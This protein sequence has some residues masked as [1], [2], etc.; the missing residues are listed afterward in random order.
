[1]LCLAACGGGGSGTISGK[2]T[3]ADGSDA[4][5]LAVTLLGPVGKRVDTISGGAYSFDKL[6]KGVYQVSVEGGDTRERRLSFGTESD[7]STAIMAPDL[8]F[9]ALATVTG[10]VMTGLGPAEGAT[11]YLSG[12]DRVAL[13]DAAGSY[14]FFEVPVG[15]YS[16]VA[17]A[18]GQVPQQASA[19]LKLKRGKNEA[20]LLTLGND[21]TVTGKLEGTL[22]LFNGFSPKD[23]RVSVAD[24]STMTSESGGFSL[25]LP[26]GEYEAIAGLAGY[27]KQSLGFATVRPG[28]TTTLPVK[29]LSV[30]KAFPWPSRISGLSWTAASESDVA[31]LQVNVD[32]DYSTEY[33]FLDTK[34]FARRLFAIGFI[35]QLHLSK[36][37]KWA[38][39]VPTSGKGVVAINSAT[40]QS[41]SLG[42]TA[43]SSGPFISNDETTMMFF[44][45][46]LLV[47]FDLNTGASNTF[48]ANAGSVFQSNERFLA[49]NT[50]PGPFDVQLITPSSA[51]TVFNSVQ[52]VGLSPA[53]FVP[54][55]QLAT[56]S[57]WAY[58]CPIGNCTVSVLGPTAASAT[59]VTAVIPS[60]PTAI[61]GSVADWI[62]LQAGVARTLIKVA[63]GTG[64]PLPAGASQLTFSETQA[65]V[66][67]HSFN[68]TL[69]TYELRED[70]VPPNAASPIHM[71]SPALAD[72]RWISPTRFMAFGAG[73]NRRVD[74]KNGDAKVDLDVT[75]N[76]V[77]Q[78]PLFFPPGVMWIKASTMKRAAAVYDSTEL[79]P[80]TL[81]I[82]GNSNFKAVSTRASVLNPSLGK[83]AGFSDGASI[84][85]LDGVKSEARRIGVGETSSNVAP[86]FPT[87]RMKIQRLGGTA[88]QFFETGRISNLSE[89]GQVIS[90]SGAASLP[91]GGT[92]V[93]AYKSSEPRNVLFLATVP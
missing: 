44:T 68:S 69:G 31:V 53:G 77:A 86:F 35:S 60:V 58:N 3:F 85:V 41:H 90:P 24:I 21:L 87:D 43:V 5:G 15:E 56:A 46:S 20:M 70:V 93:A 36:N 54:S 37:G 38:A 18:R 55:Y 51:A 13:T 39:F 59:L 88:L 79:A 81:G 73:L 48:P 19:M 11:V 2:V 57:A 33:Y 84:F 27:P 52:V 92:A 40:G 8:T 42:A 75:L 1:M 61:S 76:A 82:I 47:R 25:T 67:T 63:D 89:P 71:S 4:T 22:A 29:T 17:K 49:T 26:P 10:K 23:I 6:P 66:V 34:T 78:S 80:D 32:T 50:S 45:G 91:M 72:G 12:S 30:Y 7:G 28:Q 9:H 14:G 64:T 74:I 65:R 83:F 16:I 62:G